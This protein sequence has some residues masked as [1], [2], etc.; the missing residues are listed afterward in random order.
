MAKVRVQSGYRYV[1]TS[2]LWQR[3]ADYVQ[4]NTLTV[5]HDDFGL[6]GRNSY[7]QVC[8]SKSSTLLAVV[9]PHQW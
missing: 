4:H 6:Q 3:N 1:N 8:L 2:I 7:G 9:E 5:W